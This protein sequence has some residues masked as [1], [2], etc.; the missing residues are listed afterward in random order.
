VGRRDLQGIFGA[1][2]KDAENRGV[3]E[4]TNPRKKKVRKDGGSNHERRRRWG[5]ADG[6]S[7]EE[8]RGRREEENVTTK[9][10][11]SLGER[12]ERQTHSAGQSQRQ[13]GGAGVSGS[14]LAWQNTPIM[15]QNAGLRL[16]VAFIGRR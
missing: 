5:S 11:D 10:K 13:S 8:R 12:D 1:S 15:G 16:L 9:E 7:D 6:E 3:N 14:S 2:N 4:E